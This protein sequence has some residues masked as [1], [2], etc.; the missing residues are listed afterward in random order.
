LFTQLGIMGSQLMRAELRAREVSVIGL[1]S[2]AATAT[3]SLVLLIP[4]DQGVVSLLWGLAVGPFVGFA[5]YTVMALR[6]G[7]L[8]WTFEWDTLWRGLRFSIPLIPNLAGAWISG[9]SNRLVIAHYGTNAEV[10]LFTIAVQLGY[11]IYFVNDAITQVQGPIAMS[12][13]TEDTEAGKR[14]MSEFVSVFTWSMLFVWLA[15]TLFAKEI[16]EVLTASG[17][18]SAYTLVGPIA[19]AY[20]VAGL[21]RVFTT[22]LSYHNRL[23]VISAGALVSAALSI[24]ALFV[25]VPEYGADAAAWSFLAS[26]VVYTGWL[27]WFSQRTDPIPLNWPLLAPVVALA[28]AAIAGYLVLEELDPGTAVTVAVKSALLAVYAGS[29]FV[30]PPLAP[31]RAGV[32][33]LLRR[34]RQG[35]AA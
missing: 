10:G 32:M 35:R 23:W 8:G 24:V 7:H 20:A 26:T 2:F 12:A 22:V 21:Y 11:V 3:V 18:H 5:A 4:F 14:Q 25:F 34:I 30:L 15:V 9:F 13:L 19:A 1:V 29:I 6:E 27:A 28:A 33:T 16:L 31:L 17:Y